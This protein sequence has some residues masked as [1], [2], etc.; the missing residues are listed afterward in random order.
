MNIAS[1]GI[2]GNLLEW[3]CYNYNKRGHPFLKG[4]ASRKVGS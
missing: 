4:G 3:G 1:T 2:F